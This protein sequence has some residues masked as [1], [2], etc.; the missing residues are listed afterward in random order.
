[1]FRKPNTCPYG[2]ELSDREQLDRLLTYLTLG[3]FVSGCLERVF[4]KLRN[5][6][7]QRP[8]EIICVW[9]RGVLF[10]GGFLIVIETVHICCRRNTYCFAPLLN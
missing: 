7:L 1:M 10:H 5:I 3:V 4:S 8:D 6:M 2:V 9:D